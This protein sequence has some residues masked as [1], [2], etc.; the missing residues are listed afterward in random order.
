M[1]GLLQAIL[2]VRWVTYGGWRALFAVWAAHRRACAD[3]TGMGAGQQLMRLVRLAIGRAMPPAAA[4]QFGVIATPANGWNFIAD[5]HVLAFHRWRNAR[6][7]GAAA[8]AELLA[9]KQKTALLLAARGIPT[10][11]SLDHVVVIDPALLKALARRHGRLFCKLRSG[12]R[13]AGAFSYW[14][15]QAET[16][17][18]RL[19]GMRLSGESLD[20][21]DAVL[22]AWRALCAQGEPLVQAVLRNHPLLAPA[23]PEGVA[24]TV[25][26]ITRLGEDGLKLA[27]ACLEVPGAAGTD[28][29]R[30]GYIMVPFDLASGRLFPLP[31]PCGIAAQQTRQAAELVGRMGGEP[32]PFWQEMADH[33]LAAHAAIAD[34]WAVAWDWVVTPEGPV[35]LEGN[36]GFSGVVPQLLMG[37]FLDQRSG[38]M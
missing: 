20:N 31:D 8:A 18:E 24:I 25:R 21:D 33:S 38:W 37:G 13:G 19:A 22:S 15:S 10:A 34:L 35:L 7:P 2:W 29:R 28:G 17:Q 14:L 26:L 9:D 5:R 30:P 32:V 1:F 36:T 3:A 4:Y 16:G 12:S 11:T 6:F 27:C 23:A